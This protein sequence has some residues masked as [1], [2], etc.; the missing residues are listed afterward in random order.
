MDKVQA[1]KLIQELNRHFERFFRKLEAGL[2]KGQTDVE[3]F[4]NKYNDRQKFF[5]PLIK[6][7]DFSE[8]EKEVGRLSKIPTQL[9]PKIL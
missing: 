9:F 3:A 2:R 1:L 4:R 8:R 6:E 5:I 7:L